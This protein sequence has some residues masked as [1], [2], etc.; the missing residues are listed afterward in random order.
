M[1]KKLPRFLQPN[2]RLYFL[3]L[4][5]FTIATFFSGGYGK[6][7][8]IAQV[9]VI[10]SV[11]IY[12]RSST[13][14][15]TKKLLNY[16]ESVS[17]SMN[18]TVRATPLPVLIFNPETG[19]VIWSNDRFTAITG[20]DE[21]IFGQNVT[22]FI[23]DF[24]WD[25][26]LDGRN[27]CEEPVMIN[28]KLY[29]VYGNVVLSERE[30]VSLT[31]WVDV[32]EYTEMCSVY[33]QSRL[34]FVFITLDN[35][36]ELLKGMSAKDKS[37]LLSN[38][39]EKISAW[40]GD[41]DGYLCKFDRDRYFFLFEVRSL[42]AI[43][44]DNFSILEEIRTCVGSG[45]VQ[46]TLSIGIGR[47]GSSPQE[48]YRFASLGIEMALSRGGNQ[49]VLR[50]RYGFEFF[51]GRPQQLER[52]TKVK[53]RVMASAFGELLSD[54]SKVFIMSHKMADFDSIG[55]A[56]GIC[57]MARAKKTPAYIVVDMETCIAQNIVNLAMRHPEY[58]DVFI[59]GQDAI[60]M[61]DNKTLLV[62]VDTSRPE[63]VES[64]SLLLSCMRVAVI[65]HHRRAEDYI[66]NAL[67]N[68][69][70]PYASSSSELVAEMMQ[71]LVDRNDILRT[72]AE[73]LLAGIALDTKGFAINTGSGTF[74]AAAYLKRAGADP[75][76][77]KQIL[78]SDM[79]IATARYELLRLAQLYKG[80]IALAYNDKE[81][82]RISI[83]QAADEMLGI[84]GI[85]TSFAIA[86]DGD[87]V[88]VSGR[89]IGDVNVQV[90]LEKLGGGGSQATAGLQVTDKSVDTVVTELKKAIDGYLRRI[91][92]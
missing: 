26:L 23:N 6:I 30:Y 57:C 19:E 75:A 52:R 48:S 50:N 84:Q 35:Y 27:E 54:A 21:P 17:E 25:W 83:A 9:V 1:S 15:R 66:E 59:S 7:F 61:A 92:S 43:I 2:V 63:K 11:A 69:H 12:L 44:E 90:I 3:L 14:R 22:D 40:T 49:A 36:D 29:W 34:V 78:Q 46:A 88:Y 62:I 73:A 70:E 20:G 85:H 38:I 67:L 86:R 32:T 89:S 80:G 47:D 91:K 10:I 8:A 72:E 71:Y 13:G 53:A 4:I 81:Q 18:L 16:L 5:L 76:A 28:D 45:G 65:D 77:V 55:S 60:L 33:L 39:D 37:A 24:S 79:E 42:D 87:T 58:K 64:E 31:Y 82:C 41:K 56:M 51:G 68:F 74:D